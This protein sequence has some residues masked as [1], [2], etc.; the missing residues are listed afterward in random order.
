M[1]ITQLLIAVASTVG[2]VLVGM[3]AIIP[4]FMEA[5]SGAG[6]GSTPPR[7]PTSLRSR[8][9]WFHRTHHGRLVD[10]AA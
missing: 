4:S 8:H 10:L 1:D 3:M 2:I 5:S 9:R 7:V 6:P